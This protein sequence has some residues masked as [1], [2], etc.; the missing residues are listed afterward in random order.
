MSYPAESRYTNSA[1]SLTEPATT[2][3][4]S[5]NDTLRYLERINIPSTTDLTPSLALLDQL[6]LSHHLS[7]PYDSS[8]LHVKRQDWLGENKPIILGTGDGMELFDV[9]LGQGN[10]ERIVDR[11]S[12]GFC[13]ALNTAFAT[14]GR[15]SLFQLSAALAESANCV[16]DQLLRSLKFRVSDVGGRVYLIRGKDPATVGYKWSP[17]THQILIV[18]W[19][20]SEGKRY[21]MDAGFAGGGLTKALLI[22]DGEESNSLSETES[23]LLRKEQLIE[24]ENVFHDRPEGFTLLRRVLPRGLTIHTAKVSICS[25][26]ALLHD[27]KQ[28]LLCLSFSKLI[29]SKLITFKHR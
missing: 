24:D 20:G 11:R 3:A 4:Y 15:S 12:G 1:L 5:L 2:S 16:G 7:I 21:M 18:D 29:S 13:Y 17:I 28:T 23:F 6:L 10:F 22:R 26:S 8:S 19:P 27:S 25:F 9:R 14:V